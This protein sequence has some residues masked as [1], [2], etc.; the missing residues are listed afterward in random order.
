MSSHREGHLSHGFTL[1]EIIVALAIAGLLV[2]AVHGLFGV[3]IEQSR[4]IER[5][6]SE[7]DR[8]ENAMRWLT[9]AF[10]SV[11]V[12]RVEPGPFVGNPDDAEFTCRPLTGSGWHEPTRVTLRLVNREL[13]AGL[14]DGHAITLADSI[15]GVELDYLIESGETAP[16]LRRWASEVNAPLA[17][18]LRLRRLTNGLDASA[19]VDTSVFVIGRRG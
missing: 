18:R 3:A 2:L 4:R 6:R 1:L 15:G 13:L 9:E 10:A 16:W 14:P 7:F 8:R 19:V 17:V 5:A 12:G 11:D